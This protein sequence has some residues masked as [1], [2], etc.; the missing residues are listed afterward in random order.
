MQKPLDTALQNAPIGA[1]IGFDTAENGSFQSFR[2]RYVSTHHRIPAQ[3]TARPAERY[4]SGATGRDRVERE[5]SFGR[6]EAA[7]P[8]RQEGGAAPQPRL[9]PDLGQAYIILK[10]MY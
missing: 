8:G 6:A 4:I 10:Y 7:S 1:K 3:N 2:Y 9:A 5:R